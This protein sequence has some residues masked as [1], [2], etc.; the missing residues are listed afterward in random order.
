MFKKKEVK[1]TVSLIQKNYCEQSTT[2][3]EFK[4]RNVQFTTHIS[5]I[6]EYDP[7][8]SI[9][10]TKRNPFLENLLKYLIMFK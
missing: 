7:L 1:Q 4:M 2:D 9:N 8:E 3:V 6:D 10:L 5:K